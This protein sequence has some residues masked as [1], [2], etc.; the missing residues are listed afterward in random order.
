MVKL[1]H[2]E[3]NKAVAERDM[4]VDSLFCLEFY[5]DS[6]FTL[7]TGGTGGVLAI[8]DTEENQQVSTEFSLVK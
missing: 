6:P 8:W 1:W 3:G 4:K 2:A 5:K 7:A